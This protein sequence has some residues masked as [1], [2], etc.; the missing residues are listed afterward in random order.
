[1][2][3][4]KYL[5]KVV[6]SLVRSTKINYDTDRITIPF[7]IISVS[8][9]STITFDNFIQKKYFG[10]LIFKNTIFPSYCRHVYGLSKDEVSYVWKQYREIIKDKIENEQ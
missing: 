7:S 5:D 9:I 2:N 6:R 3:D 10:N 1:M 8:D 4:K